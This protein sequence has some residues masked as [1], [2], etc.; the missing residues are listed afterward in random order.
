MVD[1]L[2]AQTSK[3]SSVFTEEDIVDLP[4]PVQIF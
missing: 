1:S 4:V 2:L 3:E